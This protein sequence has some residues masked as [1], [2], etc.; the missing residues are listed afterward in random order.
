MS[1]I[2]LS[3]L[4]G[5]GAFFVAL[6]VHEAGHVLAGLAAGFRFRLWVVG[7][8]FLL[9]DGAGRLR[10]GWNRDLRLWGGIGATTPNDTRALIR[11]MSLVVSGGPA[12]SLGLALAAHLAL[13]AAGGGLPSAGRISLSWLRLLS[14][15]L[16]LGNAIPMENGAFRTDG[17]ALLRLLRGG[18]RTDR[19]RSVL[20]LGARQ[21][22]GERPRDWN[23]ATVA[24]AL[25]PADGSLFDLDACLLAYAH[26]LDRGDVS[27]AGPYLHRAAEMT[28]RLPRSLRASIESEIAWW[29]AW[30]GGR[31]A[32]AVRLMASIPE[33]SPWVDAW[34]H[35]RAQAAIAWAEGRSHDAAAAINRA[36][37]VVPSDAA[38]C[39]ARLAEMQAVVRG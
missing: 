13:S 7:P 10:A 16:F 19:Q 12:A 34:E 35:L 37:Q 15:L 6:A 39:R 26:A 30:H 1:R 25:E 22:R 21:S 5:L 3:G 4:F 20:E 8:V 27:E 38:F 11:R 24:G 33:S 17:S 23:P 2:L 28:P 32:D 18:P 29:E 36:L 14:G 9:R 31:T